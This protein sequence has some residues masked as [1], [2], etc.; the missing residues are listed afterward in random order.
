METKY[1]LQLISGLF[2]SQE[3]LEVLMSLFN[4]KMKFHELKNFSSMER[5][6]KEDKMSIK[7]INQLKENIVVLQELIK[8]AEEKNAPLKISSKV[9]IQVGN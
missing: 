8:I 2:S 3:A 6:G 7:K 4:S 1:K 5:K 9:T